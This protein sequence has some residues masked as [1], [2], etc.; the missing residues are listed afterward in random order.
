[1]SPEAMI[2]ADRHG[3]LWQQHDKYPVLDWQEMVANDDTRLG[4]WDW[5]IT[6]IEMETG[7]NPVNLHEDVI[8]DPMLDEEEH[9]RGRGADEF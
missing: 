2:L 9:S 7:I 6:Q 4:Y 8:S 3:G 5:V 1:M